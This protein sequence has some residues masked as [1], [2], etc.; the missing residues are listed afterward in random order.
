[1]TE[2]KADRSVTPV[3]STEQGSPQLSARRGTKTTT[4]AVATATQAKKPST[5]GPTGEEALSFAV[6]S[7]SSTRL[8]EGIHA[9]AS[10]SISAVRTAILVLGMHRSGTSALTRVVNLMGA[11][12]SAKLLGPKTDNETGFWESREVTLLDEEVLASG[13]SAWD[14]WRSFNP[15][16]LRSPAKDS[17]RARA[18]AILEKELA[19][20]RFFVL[21]DPRISRLLPF[22]LEVLREFDADPRCVISFRN[23]LEVAASLR[24]RDGFSPA[25]SY[26]LWLRHVVDAEFETRGLKRAFVSYDALLDDWRGAVSHLSGRLNIAWSRRSATAEVEIDRF[27]VHRLRHHA[28]GDDLALS[29]PEVSSWVKEAYAALSALE[30][31]PESEDALSRLETVRVEFNRASDSLGAVLRSEEIAREDLERVASQREARISELEQAIAGHQAQVAE[32]EQ[33]VAGHQAHVAELEQAVAGHQT[34][35]AELEQAAAGH[36][37]HVAELQQAASQREA[38]IGELEQTVAGHQ[39]HVAELQQAASQREAR[40]GELEQ[41][42]AG[43]QAHVAELEQA[44]AGHQASVAELQRAASQR[45]TRVNRLEQDLDGHRA[46]VAELVEAASQREVEI[47]DLGSR[48]SAEQDQKH[49]ALAQKTHLLRRLDA[50]QTTASWQLSSPLRA[51][52]SRWPRIVRGIAAVP[53]FVW[54]AL[55]FRLSQRLQVRRLATALLEKNLFDRSWYIENNPDVVLRGVNPI[56]HWLVFGWTEGRDPNPLFDTDWYLAQNPDVAKAGLNPLVHYLERG[57]SEGRDPSPL[58]DTDWYLAQNPSA[59]TAGVNALAHYLSTGKGEGRAARPPHS[60]VPALSPGV[61]ETLRLPHG[62]EIPEGIP[63]ESNHVP[64]TTAGAEATAAIA[65]LVA[66]YLPQFHPISENDTW[67]GKGFTEWTNTAKAQPLFPGHQMPNVPAD[68]GYYDLRVSESREAQAEL[69]R[70]YGLAGFCYWHYWFG[71][72]KRLLNRPFNEVVQSGRPDFPFCLAWANQTWTGIWHGAPDRTL[73]EQTYPGLD[74]FRAHFYALLK[75]FSDRRYLK[76][77][78]RNVFC[79]Y[80]PFALPEAKLFIDTWREL[81]AKEGVPGFYF[82]AITDY[83]WKTPDD[84]YDAFTTNPPVGMLPY[85]GVPPMNEEIEQIIPEGHDKHQLPQIY[86]YETFIEYAFPAATHRRDFFPCVVPNW[87]NTPRSGADG[88][89]LHG[90]TPELY[91]KHLRE[92]VTL[93]RDRSP[94]ERVIFVKSWNEW[95]ETNYLEPDLRWG[96]SYLE[97]TSTAIRSPFREVTRK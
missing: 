2:T 24:K 97:A 66:F 31:E 80:R 43:H 5:S 56:L 54:W 79:V 62:S 11:D 87:D 78:G 19:E 3:E 30:A 32:L 20:S 59:A 17:F 91:E 65:R 51:V 52:E 67:W 22:W 46:R 92:A 8:A 74:D 25:K 86:S 69:A 21:K 70:S 61:P 55:T 57:A 44:V 13:G 6:P 83:P 27:L 39:A 76:V 18:L 53:K 36:Q 95:A 72:G 88:F 68:L 26:M 14:D 40:M 58:F 47:H 34:H 75:A 41:T 93:V 84:G 77:D 60:G 64:L 48:L 1:M 90:S 23:P 82:V 12:I 63:K 38:R 10:A 45:E 50:I 4:R 33:A 15:D 85:Q 71:N 96:R 28:I 49:N 7:S 94:G 81:A 35:V 42:V 37:A 9:S 89:V 73:I 29:H 16:W